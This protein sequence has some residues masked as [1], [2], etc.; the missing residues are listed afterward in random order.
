[1]MVRSGDCRSFSTMRG[2]IWLIRWTLPVRR[3]E[4]RADWQ[5]R[6]LLSSSAG[7]LNLMELRQQTL[8]IA[9]WLRERQHVRPGD[10]VAI[11]L[12]KSL[13]AVQI[14]YGILAAGAAYVPLQFQGPPARLGTILRSIEPRLLITTAEMAAQAGGMDGLPTHIL[15]PASDG[16]GL[17]PLLDGIAPASTM[18]QAEVADLAAVFF[19]SGSTGEPKG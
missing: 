18:V 11:C 2:S 16:R 5:D 9:A 13:E 15:A 1:M 17:A 10:R 4:I 19:T 12:P 7:R 6:P 8:R 14:I 3:A